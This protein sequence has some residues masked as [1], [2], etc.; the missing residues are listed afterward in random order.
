MSNGPYTF[1]LPDVSPTINRINSLNLENIEQAAKEG[2]QTLSNIENEI[3]E[4]LND[5]LKSAKEKVNEAGQTPF[6]F[7]DFPNQMW[8]FAI[9]RGYD[10]GKPEQHHE[11]HNGRSGTDRRGGGPEDSPTER[12]HKQLR[13]VQVLRGAGDQLHLAA[14]DRLHRTRIDMWHLRQEA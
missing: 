13:A 12:V 10:Q 8:N 2:Q 5:T 3:N 9:F 1:Q 11:R 6:S 7:V 14:G 4:R